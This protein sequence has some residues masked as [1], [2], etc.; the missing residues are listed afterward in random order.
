M[1]PLECM[2]SEKRNTSQFVVVFSVTPPPLP[3][4]HH[5]IN[6][7]L[8]DNN[9]RGT[10]PIVTFCGIRYRVVWKAIELRWIKTIVLS[11]YRPCEPL[12]AKRKRYFHNPLLKLCVS[13]AVNWFIFDLFVNQY[14]TNKCFVY[15]AENNCAISFSS[16]H[17]DFIIYDTSRVKLGACYW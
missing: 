2:Y 15:T 3:L 14:I 8:T 9:M 4:H 7:T 11:F 1:F 16:T 5:H 17:N 6:I 10:W 12:E 13:V